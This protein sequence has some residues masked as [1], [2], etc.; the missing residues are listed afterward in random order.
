[1]T[2]IINFPLQESRLSDSKREGKDLKED[3]MKR[4]KRDS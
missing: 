4:K 3:K 2:L 1:M